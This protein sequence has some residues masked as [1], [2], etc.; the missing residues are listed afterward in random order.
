[1]R[2]LTPQDVVVGSPG[3][4]SLGDPQRGAVTVLLSGSAQPVKLA[5]HSIY[6]R[7]GAACAVADVNADGRA[8]LLVGA[9]QTNGL[10]LVHVAGNYTG[11]VF[12]FFGSARGLS[13]TPNLTITGAGAFAQLGGVISPLP[14]F[15]IAFGCPTQTLPAGPQTGMVAVL[16]PSSTYSTTTTVDVQALCLLLPGPAAFSLFGSAVALVGSAGHVLIGAPGARS[17]QGSVGAAM[18]FVFTRTGPTSLSARLQTTILSEDDRSAFGATLATGASLVAIGSPSH[19]RGLIEVQS[20]EQAGRVYIATVAKLSALP[21]GNVSVASVGWTSTHDGAGD[22][23][24]LGSALAVVAVHGQD[25]VAMGGTQDDHE[26]GVVSVWA[27]AGPVTRTIGSSV[28]ERF[29][30]ALLALPA[31]D[32]TAL[33][34]ASAPRRDVTN[35]DRAGAVDVWTEG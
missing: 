8:D 22:F 27:Q 28:N 26:R 4:G 23:S 21:A 5:G 32:G 30:T 33:F 17:V 16:C 1:V 29:G 3:A 2:A 7:F 14:G 6:G 10:D 25:V 11:A 9:P 13:L 24:K 20:H 15:G 18:L 12:A 34:Y 19:G 35:V 31:P